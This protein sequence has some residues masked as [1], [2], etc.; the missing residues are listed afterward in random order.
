MSVRVFASLLRLDTLDRS[1]RQLRL[2]VL[3]GLLAPLSEEVDHVTFN[4]KRNH[5]RTSV[6]RSRQTN[7]ESGSARLRGL[8]Q[9][10]VRVVRGVRKALLAP[11]FADHG[12]NGD[13]DLIRRFF[14]YFNFY[15]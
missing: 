2:L 11:L 7:C 3:V 15:V 1:I 8:L 9:A 4:V 12:R 5:R 13:F 14:I 10:S 6:G